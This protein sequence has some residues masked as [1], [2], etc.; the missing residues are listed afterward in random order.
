VG[1]VNVVVTIG[2]T[3]YLVQAQTAISYMLYQT[4]FGWA[5]GASLSASQLMVRIDQTVVE[6]LDIRFTLPVQFSLT[7]PL[8]VGGGIGQK[9]MTGATVVQV[10]RA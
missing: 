10:I 6:V 1:P 3:A 8:L 2:P 4:I 9:V 5:V 7:P